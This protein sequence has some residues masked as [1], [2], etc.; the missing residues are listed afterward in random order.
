M[1][2]YIITITVSHSSMGY[3]VIPP[4]KEWTPHL[5]LTQPRSAALTAFTPLE[6]FF[7]ERDDLS[8]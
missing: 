5:A 1:F 7:G 4:S 6:I 2:F 8:P 3:F